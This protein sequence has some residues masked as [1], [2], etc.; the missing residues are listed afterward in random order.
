MHNIAIVI[1][2]KR[3]HLSLKFAFIKFI[4]NLYRYYC[5]D[6]GKHIL[7]LCIGVIIL[8]LAGIIM[9]LMAK[10]MR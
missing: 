4:I 10:R 6:S 8:W 7:N 2:V 9:F 3:L 5:S 1:A